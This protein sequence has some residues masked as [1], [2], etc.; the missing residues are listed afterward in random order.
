M[1]YVEKRRSV[2]ENETV[3]VL[4]VWSTRTTSE[5]SRR[6]HTTRVRIATQR[7]LSRRKENQRTTR[8]EATKKTAGCGV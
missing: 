8:Q 5:F 1:S 2:G 3:P 4:G 7:G 6:R